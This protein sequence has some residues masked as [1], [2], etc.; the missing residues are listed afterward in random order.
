M[1]TGVGQL[2][3]LGGHIDNLTGDQA[4]VCLRELM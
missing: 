3:N 4:H 2:F 1:Q